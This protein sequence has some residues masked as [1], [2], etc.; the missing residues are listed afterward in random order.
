MI[1]PTNKHNGSQYLLPEIIKEHDD[2]VYSQLI[3]LW[4]VQ[5]VISEDSCLTGTISKHIHWLILHRV[6]FTRIQKQPL[7]LVAC[8]DG[9][10]YMFTIEA[11]ASGN[12]CTLL[13]Q[14]RSVCVCACMCF[15]LILHCGHLQENK[16]KV[17]SFRAT[18]FIGCHCLPIADTSLHCKTSNT[19]LAHHT[20]CLFTY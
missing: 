15:Y 1:Q 4:S 10:L 18:W 2:Y 16:V 11:L 19:W 9:W 6:L 14:H 7:L 12:E 3:R 8:E 17:E 20:V 5:S 13:Y